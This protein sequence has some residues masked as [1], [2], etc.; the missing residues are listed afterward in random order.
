[1]CVNEGMSTPWHMYGDETT[2]P[3]VSPHRLPFSEMESFV[4]YYFSAD[5]LACLSLPMPIQL[6]Q[7]RQGFSLLHLLSY[8]RKSGVSFVCL[9]LCGL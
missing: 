3:N 9:A 4:V 2:V 5:W 6:A 7:E 1:M 8:C